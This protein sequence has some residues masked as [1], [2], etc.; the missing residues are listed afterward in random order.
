MDWILVR[1]VTRI[2]CWALI[3]PIKNKQENKENIDFIGCL[4]MQNTKRELQ[5]N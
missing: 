1:S 5:I 3:S 2:S 4:K